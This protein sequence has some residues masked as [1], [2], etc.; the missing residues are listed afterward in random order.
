MDLDGKAAVITGGASGLGKTTALIMASKGANL[1]IIVNQELG[2]KTVK[3]IEN[4]G[5]RAAFMRADVCDSEQ[6]KSA[7]AE[8]INRF[9][10][11]DILSNKAGITTP[12]PGFTRLPIFTG[13]KCYVR[14]KARETS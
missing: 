4:K 7:F 13:E 6:M 5:P 8:I 12:Q 2:D 9:G 3:L 1:M 11:F 10:R 14:A